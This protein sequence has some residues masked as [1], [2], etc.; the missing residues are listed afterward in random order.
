L[1]VPLHTTAPCHLNCFLLLSLPHPARG[2]VFILFLSFL[3][4]LT[5]TSWPSRRPWL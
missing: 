1:G 4:L 2:M 5:L 3:P